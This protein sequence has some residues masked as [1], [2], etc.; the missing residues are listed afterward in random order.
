MWVLFPEKKH[1]FTGK[2]M[3]LDTKRCEKL[4]LGK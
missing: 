1:V 3:F 2:Y 4:Y